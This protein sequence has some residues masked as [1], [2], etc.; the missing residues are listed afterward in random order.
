MV[1]CRVARKLV[2]IYRN[3]K[4]RARDAKG[5]KGGRREETKRR[6]E[7]TSCT[8]ATSKLTT[9]KRR[10]GIVARKSINDNDWSTCPGNKLD[11]RLCQLII[12]VSIYRPRRG[13]RFMFK[14]IPWNLLDNSL[15][16]WHSRARAAGLFTRE[17]YTRAGSYIFVRMKNNEPPPSREAWLSLEDGPLEKTPVSRPIGAFRAFLPLY[18]INPECILRG[19]GCVCI[20]NIWTY[21]HPRGGT[22]RDKIAMQ[23]W[24]RR[25]RLTAAWLK[26]ILIDGA[27]REK[28]RER[29][30]DIPLKGHVFEAT[31]IFRE[32]THA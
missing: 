13:S 16:Y 15:G 21:I 5:G 4:P 12:T 20:I 19:G 30:A 28:E 26:I 6:E 1:N 3:V 17:T 29:A 18:W 24:G 10:R 11:N 32:R 23:Q 25:R 22:R 7:R 2:R 31:R 8:G 9:K 27:T 14:Q